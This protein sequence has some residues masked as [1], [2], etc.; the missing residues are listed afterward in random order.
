MLFQWISSNGE[1]KSSQGSGKTKNEVYAEDLDFKH[2]KD[3]DSEV[4]ASEISNYKESGI[5]R[6]FYV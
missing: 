3:K 2:N 5:E 1:G 4:N 6:L